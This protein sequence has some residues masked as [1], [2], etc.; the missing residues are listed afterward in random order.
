[1]CIR[2]RA[3]D[4]YKERLTT[5]VPP[6]VEVLAIA[7]EPAIIP[8]DDIFFYPVD[9]IVY[10]QYHHNEMGEEEE[11]Q[12]QQQQQSSYSSSPKKENSYIFRRGAVGFISEGIGDGNERS[13]W[14]QQ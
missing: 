6:Q 14:L 4:D 8:A 3:T 12:Q 7:E 5:P 10:S 1:M 13:G 9:S 11:I 2:D